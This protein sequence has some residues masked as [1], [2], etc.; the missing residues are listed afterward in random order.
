MQIGSFVLDFTEKRTRIAVLAV[1]LALVLVLVGIG[2]VLLTGDDTSKPADTSAES[3]ATSDTAS[4]ST[5]GSETGDAEQSSTTGGD[6]TTVSTANSQGT[7]TTTTRGGNNT[8]VNPPKPGKNAATAQVK[9][10]NGLPKLYVNGKDTPPLLTF[11]NT[12]YAWYA[13]TGDR[14]DNEL[15]MAAKAGINVVSVPVEIGYMI[16]TEQYNFGEVDAVLMSAISNNPNC[17]ILLRVGVSMSGAES[18]QWLKNWLDKN[19]DDQ[20]VFSD[21]S[22]TFDGSS[23]GVSMASEKW[24]SGAKIALTKMIEHIDKNPEFKNRVIGYHPTGAS[25][26]EWFQWGCREKGVDV[27][28]ANNKG[29][30]AWLKKKYGTDSKLRSAWADT[31]VTLNTAKVPVVPGNANTSY[32]PTL[33]NRPSDQKYIDFYEY[34][35]WL[36]NDRILQLSKTVKTVTNNRC[37]NVIF[38]GYDFE[39][40]TP[41]SGHNSFRPLLESP[42]IDGFASPISYYDRNDGGLGSFMAPVDSVQS[43]GKLWFIESDI[44]T[45]SNP[46][47]PDASYNPACS[48]INAAVEVHKRDF[49]AMMTRGMATWWMDLWGS[50]WLDD[51]KIWSNV[52]QLQPL[53]KSYVDSLRPLAGDKTAFKPE[54]AVV[55]DQDGTFRYGSP[56]QTL[57]QLLSKGVRE[58]IYRA[59]ITVGY[60]TTA[61]LIKGNIPSSVKLFVMPNAWHIDDSEMAGIMK[62]QKKGN[63]F[64]YLSG[65]G[66]N[67]AG[68]VKQMTGM[69]MKLLQAGSN[70]VQVVNNN[71]TLTKGLSTISNTFTLNPTFSLSGGEILG[72]SGSANSLAVKNNGTYKAIYAGCLNPTSEFYR[73]V[74]RYAGVNVFT[75]SGDT[76]T[77]NNEFLTIHT[78]KNASGT[79]KVSFGKKVDVYDYFAD[80]W[81]EDVT[82]ISLPVKPTTT[83][84]LFYG[85][86]ATL[87]KKG[88]HGMKG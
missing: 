50:G 10:V 84:Y 83:Y 52:A 56:M 28:E 40:S 47:E 61:D 23:V 31:S 38:Y 63:T 5:S 19:P 29:F 79:R 24:I 68:R 25:T 9:M 7:V 36:V 81:Y 35:A 3:S 78:Q 12:P 77:G 18:T 42:Y 57:D 22:K 62:Y 76:L 11:V 4:G 66:D 32:T 60:Y 6:S 59:G 49:G 27:S 43:A 55:L 82:S 86:K 44:R 53:Y 65:F 80:K 20:T 26:G 41:I 33:L 34:N 8:V 51:S 72:R 69:D 1:L 37:L 54:V 75:E 48:S 58:S 46:S 64:L 67:S 13:G 2:I 73:N 30:R 16:S 14:L 87:M 21:G 88:I 74:A 17:F 85:D 70:Q 15:Q 45:F 39:I 71:H